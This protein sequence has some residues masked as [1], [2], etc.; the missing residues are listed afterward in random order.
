MLNKH[1][2]SEDVKGYL[3]NKHLKVT[4]RVKEGLFLAKSGYVTSM[5]DL[6]D[7]VGSDMKRI[8]DESGVGAEIYLNMLPVSKY[9]K[10]LSR[11]LN[12]NIYDFALYGG[13]DYEI[14][15]T[16]KTDCEE[17]LETGFKKHFKKKIFKIGTITKKAK[18]RSIDSNGNSC[19]ITESYNHF[20]T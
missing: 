20:L 14:L 3:V 19:G 2:I 4:P 13:E 9:L 8:C 17:K 16:V 5:I 1:K 12:K 6:S 15:F 10:K 18:I 7:G 11:H